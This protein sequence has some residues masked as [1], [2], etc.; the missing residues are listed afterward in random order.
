MKTKNSPS[1]ASTTRPGEVS[2]E[3]KK[4]Q[5]RAAKAVKDAVAE[6]QALDGEFFVFILA[7]YQ[8]GTV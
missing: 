7:Q 8:L 6:G 5:T 2:A 4:R 3:R 1:R